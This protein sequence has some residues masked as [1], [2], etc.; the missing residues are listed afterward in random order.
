M[1]RRVVV[2]GGTGFLGRRVVRHLLSRGFAVR[3]ASRHPEHGKTAFPDAPSQL[4]LI[5]ADIGDDASVRDAVG[6]TFG[7]VNAVS[8]YVE[9][10]NQTFSS[11]HVEA[12]ARLARHSRDAGVA[13]LVHVSGIGADAGS[14]SPYIRSRGEGEDAVRAALPDATIIRP[15]VMFGTDD[16][17]LIPLM[18][19]LRKFPVFPLFG[20]GHTRLQPVYVDDVGEAIAR[21]VDAPDAEPIYEFAGPRVY[22]RRAAIIV[23]AAESTD[24]STATCI[25]AQAV[26]SNIQAGTS[27]Q[28]SAPAPLRLQ[29]KTMPSGLSMA[30]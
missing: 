6:G 19:L 11:V 5:R 27:S 20:S 10:D 22:C 21:V 4:E 9:R 26:R 16:A 25:R 30:A 17:F 12:A 14:P 1:T 18:G 8:L 24:A 13:R 23:S 15:A 29:R 7:V 28:R 3:V 2:F